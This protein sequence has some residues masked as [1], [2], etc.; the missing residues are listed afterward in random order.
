MFVL[1]LGSK[2]QIMTYSEALRKRLSWTFKSD[3]LE[4][5]KQIINNI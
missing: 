4:R 1:V 5:L 3:N 2:P